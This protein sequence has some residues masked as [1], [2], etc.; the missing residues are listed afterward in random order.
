M[1]NRV[2]DNEI[3]MK[4]AKTM[5]KRMGFEADTAENG[6]EA[7]AKMHTKNYHIVLM[8]S[9]SLSQTFKINQRKE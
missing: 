3:N 5:L 1:L 8:V 9:L 7:V 6:L 2:E 4:I